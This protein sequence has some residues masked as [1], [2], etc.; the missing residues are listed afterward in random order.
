M[1]AGSECGGAIQSGEHAL[2]E[3]GP[4]LRANVQHASK[5]A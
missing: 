2:S 4:L 1:A 3:L 5:W